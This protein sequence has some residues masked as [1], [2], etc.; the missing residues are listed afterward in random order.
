MRFSAHTT[1]HA[2]RLPYVMDNSLGTLDEL[3]LQRGSVRMLA[4]E[5][6]A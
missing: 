5:S 4:L 6:L 1:P 2:E 3:P